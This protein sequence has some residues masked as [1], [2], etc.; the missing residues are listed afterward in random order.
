[1]TVAAATRDELTPLRIGGRCAV[2]AV[3]AEDADGLHLPERGAQVSIRHP[4]EALQAHPI[5][6]AAGRTYTFPSILDA[7]LTPWMDRYRDL[8]GEQVT[9]VVGVCPRWWA[10]SWRDMYR[11]ALQQHA[12]DAE[13]IAESDAVTAGVDLDAAGTIAVWDVGKSHTAVTVLGRGERGGY[14][15]V[16]D[17]A[18]TP[19][20]GAVAIDRHICRVL[21]WPDT[22]TSLASAKTLRQK[23]TTSSYNAEQIT[24]PAPGDETCTITVRE[25]IDIIAGHVEQVVSALRGRVQVASADHTVA[26]GGMSQDKGVQSALRQYGHLHVMDLPETVLACGAAA[27]G[28]DR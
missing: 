28:G 2:P 11:R 17:H 14:R 6:S 1:M 18:F 15:E 21:N 9:A 20:G 16:V 12:P 8:T 27:W 13:V 4:L 5:T 26:I 7:L 22:A 24:V 19:D 25:G 23:I 3:L 10:R